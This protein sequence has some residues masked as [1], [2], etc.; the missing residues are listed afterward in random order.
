M[1][2]GTVKNAFGTDVPGALTLVTGSVIDPATPSAL[3]VGV[4]LSSVGMFDQFLAPADRRYTLNHYNYDDQMAL[5][6]PRAVAYS[7]GLLD[8]FFRGQ[9]EIRLP[10]EGVYS[11]VDHAQFEPPNSSIDPY[12]GYKGFSK[13][14]LRLLNSTPPIIT[15]PD[16][17]TSRT[18]AGTA[19]VLA[20]RRNLRYATRSMAITNPARCQSVARP[21]R[22]CSFRSCATTAVPDARA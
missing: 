12:A 6:L 4:R 20:F 3:A 9:M 10:D 14:R 7:A 5:L 2:N 17:T 8:F 16:S 13:L 21:M 11:I 19:S 1:V 15:T 22:D 18:D